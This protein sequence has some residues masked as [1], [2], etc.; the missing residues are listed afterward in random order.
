MG[1]AV[2]IIVGFDILFTNTGYEPVEKI[3]YFTRP[4]K[5]IEYV[6]QDDSLF[7]I[8]ASPS[9][10][11]K[12][13]F[14]PEGFKIG[15]ESTKDRFM[16]NRM[17]EYGLYDMW[18]YGSTVLRRNCDIAHIIYGLKAPSDTKLIDLLNVKYIASCNDIKAYGYEKVNQT[19]YSSVFRNRSYLPRAFLVGKI[20]VI[21]DKDKR[22]EFISSMDFDPEKEVI[23]EEELSLEPERRRDIKQNKA[24]ITIYEPAEVEI[25]THAKKESIL[26]LG[27]TYYNGWKAYVDGREKKIYIADHFLRA[28]AVPSGIHTVRFVFKPLSFKI[29]SIVTFISMLILVFVLFARGLRLTR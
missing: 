1:L 23:L 5:N 21:K 28:V 3:S 8:M 6:K 9:A 20:K 13:T 16:N 2:F 17:M 15:V 4:S 25:K 7:R 10:F 19:K 26:V 24:E 29:G 11:N 14:V 18:G 12:F 27:D 22:L